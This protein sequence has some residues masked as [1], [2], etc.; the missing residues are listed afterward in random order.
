MAAVGALQ[1]GE[2]KLFEGQPCGV[3]FKG[4]QLE[5]VMLPEDND[6]GVL[7]EDEVGDEEELETESGCDSVIGTH[8]HCGRVCCMS[9][10]V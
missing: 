10:I 6:M 4:F 2:E 8:S 5:D 1:P 9:S 7:S 3:P